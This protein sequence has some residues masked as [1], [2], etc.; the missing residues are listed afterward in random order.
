[1]NKVFIT[2]HNDNSLI[3]ISIF[4]YKKYYLLCK[5]F[6]FKKLKKLYIYKDNYFN[7]NKWFKNSFCL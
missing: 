2:K 4:K 6:N 3:T 5:Q 1:M 7:Y